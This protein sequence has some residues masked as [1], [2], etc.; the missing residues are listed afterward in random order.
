ML[1]H[2]LYLI[3]GDQ[4]TN[5]AVIRSLERRERD[6]KS[7]SLSQSSSGNVE[8]VEIDKVEKNLRQKGYET[9]EIAKVEKKVKK[10]ADSGWHFR[11]DRQKFKM[12]EN[13]KVL[14]S[15]TKW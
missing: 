10:K 6:R 14:R 5:T 9:V 7:F 11:E 1:L 4:T 3:M 8:K 2:E 12:I 13:E 15:K